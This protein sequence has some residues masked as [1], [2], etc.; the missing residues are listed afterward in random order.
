MVTWA[1]FSFTNVIL[2][3]CLFAV[4]FAVNHPK[5]VRTT[6]PYLLLCLLQKL[7]FVSDGLFNY[8]HP[9]D[10]RW[11]NSCHLGVDLLDGTWRKI[12]ECCE[13]TAPTLTILINSK[14]KPKISYSG[15]CSHKSYDLG[16][17]P[18]IV[19]LT[20]AMNWVSVMVK[21]PKPEWGS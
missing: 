21:C 8:L 12:L 13:K 14:W 10:F 11:S 4:G 17:E 9:T 5:W 3:L 20:V 1:D 16:N 6:L 18:A 15:I 7:V 19:Y 2:K